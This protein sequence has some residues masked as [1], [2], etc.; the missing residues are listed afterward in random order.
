MIDVAPLSARRVSTIFGAYHY[1]GAWSVEQRTT[2][3]DRRGN[4]DGD[5][6][7]VAVG[8]TEADARAEAARLNAGAA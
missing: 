1:D 5:F 6:T 4:W 8:L 2:W 7:R 3:R